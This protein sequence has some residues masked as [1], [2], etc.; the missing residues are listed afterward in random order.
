MIVCPAIFVRQRFY[1]SFAAH[2]AGQ[3]LRAITFTNRGM[4]ISLAAERDDWAHQLRHW[5]ELD[6]PA[7]IALARRT[8]PNDRLYLV[9]HSMG[10]QVAALS[11]AVHQLEGIVTVAATSSWWGHWPLPL[12]LG[13]LAWYWMVPLVG[14]A[15]RTFP[16]ER[17]GL[18]PDVDSRLV[19]DWARWGRHRDYLHGPFGLH[20]QMASYEG[21][22]L[23][24]SF[25]DDGHLGCRR[26]VEALHSNYQRAR[27]THRHV[28]PQEVGATRLGHFG[29]FRQDSGEPLWQQ[30]ISWISGG[31]Q[32]GT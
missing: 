28:D 14:R 4:G 7:V 31:E 24:Y 32:G 10:G 21:R 2:L 6:L 9:G 16:A 11:E 12:N 26:A 30:T 25:T 20:P 23:V 19:R 18:G 27:I 8:R 29:Y 3:G 5:G 22:V 17:L 15:L 13:I 1:Y